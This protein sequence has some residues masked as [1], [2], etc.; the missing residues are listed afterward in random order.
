MRRAA[1]EPNRLTRREALLLAASAA[2]GAAGL[3]GSTRV[4]SADVPSLPPTPTPSPEP[5]P[6]ATPTPALNGPERELIETYAR[7]F[8]TLGPTPEVTV[9][10]RADVAVV[11]RDRI[12]FP[13]SLFVNAEEVKTRQEVELPL[14]FG[15]AVLRSLDPGGSPG[16]VLSAFGRF[17]TFAELTIGPGEEATDAALDCY[18]PYAYLSPGRYATERQALAARLKEPEVLFAATV[19]TWMVFPDALLARYDG[20]P[21]EPEQYPERGSVAQLA[22]SIE[23]VTTHRIMAEVYALAAELVQGGATMG[24]GTIDARLAQ[25]APRLPIVKFGMV[26]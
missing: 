4:F 18:N 3:A 19:T 8:L 24:E 13:A 6:T 14:A 5:V 1:A 26:L 7:R 22:P 23:K 2:F 10:D 15:Q 17:R 25:L 11:H 16:R 9:S 12:V 20:M 21:M